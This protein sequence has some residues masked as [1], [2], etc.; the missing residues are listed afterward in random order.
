MLVGPNP[1]R[2]HAQGC[3]RP[4]AV[5]A[6]RQDGII[7]SAQQR[8]TGCMLRTTTVCT[9]A[10]NRRVE[11]PSDGAIDRA[12]DATDEVLARGELWN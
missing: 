4:H 10:T 11:R 8:I 5:V 1:N 2:A 3:R 9:S 12:D 7:E 6:A